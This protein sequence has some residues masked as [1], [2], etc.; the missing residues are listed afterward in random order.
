MISVC[1][2]RR[3]VTFRAQSMQGRP[4]KGVSNAIPWYGCPDGLN[5]H[6]TN[7]RNSEAHRA[8]R[9]AVCNGRCIDPQVDENIWIRLRTLPTI[10]QC[11]HHSIT[12]LH[13]TSVNSLRVVPARSYHKCCRQ[14][15]VI[16]T[17]SPLRGPH[18]IA[19][20]MLSRH[21]ERERKQRPWSSKLG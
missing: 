19:A 4:T 2:L 15:T 11:M 13:D 8:F 7:T 21:R 6:L 17:H 1:D 3:P 10:R 5:F 14:N 16:F 12:T 20:C 9:I 18:F